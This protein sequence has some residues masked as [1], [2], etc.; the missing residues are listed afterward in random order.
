MVQREVLL[1]GSTMWSNGVLCGP[2]CSDMICCGH[3][4]VMSVNQNQQGFVT[5]INRQGRT[6]GGVPPPPPPTP[7]LRPKNTLLSGFLPLNY[8]ICVFAA[9]LPSSNVFL[10]RGS[11]EEACSMVVS[12]RKV[13][14]LYP[15]GH[16]IYKIL[17]PP[18]LDKIMGA[19]LFRVNP[20][21]F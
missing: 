1:W 13:D 20:V 14:I 18:P 2:R 8:V 19:P 6:Q 10:V 4:V 16:Y 9:C 3:R 7:A 17:R 5:H 11:T 15:T 21:C 12:L